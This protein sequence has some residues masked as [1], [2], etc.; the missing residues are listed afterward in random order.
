MRKSRHLMEM[1]LGRKLV[2]GEVVHHIDGNPMNNRLE[3]LELFSS[4]GDHLESH[5]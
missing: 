3:N 4:H 2:S 5:R 1:K